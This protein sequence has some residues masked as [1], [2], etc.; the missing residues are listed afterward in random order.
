[1]RSRG[2]PTAGAGASTGV[3]TSPSDIFAQ[4]C[5]P[6]K[7]PTVV[8]QRKEKNNDKSRVSVSVQAPKKKGK[9]LC[10]KVR[11]TWRLRHMHRH[12]HGELLTWLTRVLSSLFGVR[13]RSPTPCCFSR[14]QTEALAAA[15]GGE[16]EIS[17][18]G[19]DR[20]K[21]RRP[22][23]EIAFYRDTNA[24]PRNE[25]DGVGSLSLSVVAGKA[26]ELRRSSSTS[27]RPRSQHEDDN[28]QGVFV[29][30]RS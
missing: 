4:N 9:G 25:S 27:G 7:F 18:F 10:C 13:V 12:R 19:E 8:R 1:M 22:R 26:P 5:P 11:G 15:C 14:S 16:V 23:V 28:L 6:L 24:K 29:N 30:L 21:S 17:I 3:S 20:E 2:S